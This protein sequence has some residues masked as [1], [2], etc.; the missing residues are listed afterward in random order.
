MP[1]A[2][3]LAPDHYAR[4]AAAARLAQVLAAGRPIAKVPKPKW[5]TWTTRL[6]GVELAAASRRARRSRLRLLSC[7]VAMPADGVLTTH[8]RGAGVPQS[9]A[10]GKGHGENL[11]SSGADLE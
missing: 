6:C 2:N 7:P 10:E 4:L 9:I 5:P 11:G 3:A 8:S 1:R